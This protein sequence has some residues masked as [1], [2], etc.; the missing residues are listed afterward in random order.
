LPGKEDD[1]LVPFHWVKIVSSPPVK[2][3][4]DVKKLCNDHGADLVGGQ[5]YYDD[6]EGSAFA[7]VKGPD[8]EQEQKA[9]LDALQSLQ[10]IGLV[11]ADEKEAGK[12]PPKSGHKP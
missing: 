3:R 4:N 11:D 2:R 8:G 7:L 9:L 1:L 6:E 5:I 10:W 12:K